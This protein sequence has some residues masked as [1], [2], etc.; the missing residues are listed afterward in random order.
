M[1]AV[2]TSVVIDEMHLEPLDQ[3]PASVSWNCD[4]CGQRRR[5]GPRYRVLV[6]SRSGPAA[7]RWLE[8]CLSCATKAHGGKPPP[9]HVSGGFPG[10]SELDH[11]H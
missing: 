10:D 8:A 2:I 4:F 5:D 11:G 3:S 6:H 9:A 7:R 1:P